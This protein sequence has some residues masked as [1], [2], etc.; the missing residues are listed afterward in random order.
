MAEVTL[1]DFSYLNGLALTTFTEAGPSFFKSR[2]KVEASHK[3]KF[4]KL[5]T[6]QDQLVMTSVVLIVK[7]QPCQPPLAKRYIYSCHGGVEVW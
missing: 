6:L 5:S 2:F 4:K 7:G 1:I 3:K